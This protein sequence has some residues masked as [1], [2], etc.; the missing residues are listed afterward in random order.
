MKSPRKQL[1]FN[2]GIPKLD[3]LYLVYGSSG[4]NPGIFLVTAGYYGFPYGKRT[5]TT[6]ICDWNRAWY[7]T[8]IPDS[9]NTYPKALR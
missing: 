7:W 2:R 3:G 4:A 9:I 8:R 5:L 1:S 6:R